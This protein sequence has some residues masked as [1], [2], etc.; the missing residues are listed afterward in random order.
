MPYVFDL[1]R[2]ATS[3]GLAPG[4]P[5]TIGEVGA[6]ILQGYRK[7]LAKPRPTLLGEPK[8]WMHPLLEYS[9]HATT[10]FWRKV[11][12]YPEAKPPAKVAAGLKQSL[13]G[14]ADIQRF[15]SRAVG[16]AT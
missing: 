10:K 13:P 1:V 6:A 9:S 5:L 7:G 14:R 15:C 16:G 12:E 8:A 2:L 11:N 4:L 3:A